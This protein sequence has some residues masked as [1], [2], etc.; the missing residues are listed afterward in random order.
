MDW[1]AEGEVCMRNLGPKLVGLAAVVLLSGCA[2]APTA[3]SVAIAPGPHKTRAEFAND[4]AVCASLAQ[5]Q[6]GYSAQQL[7]NQQAAYALGAGA[8]GAVVGGIAGGGQGA[9]IGAGSGVLAGTALGA[10]A[11]VASQPGLQQ[12]YDAVYSQCMFSRG[13]VVPGY[14]APAYGMAPERSELV[15]S[16]QHELIRLGYLGGGADG[17]YGP[18]TRDA[19][20][21]YERANGL[22]VDG[23]P[24]PDLLA[25]LQ[26]S[27]A[28][29]R[30]SWVAPTHA[31]SESQPGSTWVSPGPAAPGPEAAPATAPGSSTWVSPG[32]PPATNMSH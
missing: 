25:S 27:T 31:A 4:Q 24:S 28:V 3:P 22:A 15:Y 5:Q 13:N 30:R 8:L 23:T 21:R 17:V 1:A 14:G 20:V 32:S 10:G 12:Q 9:A 11:N 16:V 18:R 6:T 7:N 19:I 26:S 29:A 2:V